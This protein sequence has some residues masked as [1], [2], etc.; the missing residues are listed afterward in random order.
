[1]LEKFLVINIVYVG[2]PTYMFALVYYK[3]VIFAQQANSRQISLSS[4]VGHT[5]TNLNN[6]TNS[7]TSPSQYK[8]AFVSCY[9][10]PY[11]QWVPKPHPSNPGRS[12]TCLHQLQHDLAWPLTL[13]VYE[14]SSVIKF[15]EHM[16][17]QQGPAKRILKKRLYSAEQGKL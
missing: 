9:G 14:L 15:V 5:W 6:S 11:L 17:E 1:M 3:A 12:H 8:V 2:C 7:K 16:W 13:A 10:F 4:C